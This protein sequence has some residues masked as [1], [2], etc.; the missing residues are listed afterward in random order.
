MP[1]KFEGAHASL[2]LRIF[3]S[4]PIKFRLF[5]LRG[6]GAPSLQCRL[7]CTLKFGQVKKRT[8]LDQ[9]KKDGTTRK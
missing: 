9:F 7:V 6:P 4:L 8:T 3:N 2:R 5:G 1:Y